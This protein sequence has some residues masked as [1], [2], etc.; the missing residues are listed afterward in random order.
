MI[1]NSGRESQQ[2]PYK[3]LERV[4]GKSLGSGIPQMYFKPELHCLCDLDQVT[5]LFPK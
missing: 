4:V 3:A 5:S 2:C 1:E